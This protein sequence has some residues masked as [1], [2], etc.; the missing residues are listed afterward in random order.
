LDGLV[1]NPDLFL[2]WTFDGRC[3]TVLINHDL[4]ALTPGKENLSKLVP[5][6]D[7]FC[8]TNAF[9]VAYHGSR[10]LSIGARK[11]YS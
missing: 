10:R 1:I 8:K 2:R 3:T 6:E 5:A 9:C 7:N 11:L 4:R